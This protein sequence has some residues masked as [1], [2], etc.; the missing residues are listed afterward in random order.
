M[1]R[2]TTRA[3]YN[4]RCSYSAKQLVSKLGTSEKMC[5]ERVF[6]S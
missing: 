3:Q 2:V 1:A 4:V 5:L 6:E